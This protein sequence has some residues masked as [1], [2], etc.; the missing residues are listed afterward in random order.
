MLTI[1][2]SIHRFNEILIKIPAG[3][4]FG[5]CEGRGW[6]WDFKTCGNSK[7]PQ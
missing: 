6:Q 4:V 3:F 1:S 5:D 2:K 7:D